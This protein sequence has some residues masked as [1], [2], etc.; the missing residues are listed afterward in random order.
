MICT[1]WNHGFRVGYVCMTRLLRTFLP[2]GICMARLLHGIPKRQIY[3]LDDIII[4]VI[5]TM[6]DCYTKTIIKYVSREFD[7]IE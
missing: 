3:D 2:G 6:R 4:D 5:C 7:P 1:I